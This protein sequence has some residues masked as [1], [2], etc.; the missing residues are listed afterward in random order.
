MRLLLIAVALAAT[1]DAQ[2]PTRDDYHRHLPP[3]PSIVAQTDASARLNLYGNRAAAGYVDRNPVDG[4][5]DARARRLLTIV[6]RFSPILRRNNFAIPR[7]F[8]DLLPSPR[9]LHVDVWRGGRRISSDSI[10]ID[11]A[12]AAASEGSHADRPNVGAAIDDDKLRAL[13]DALHPRRSRSRIVPASGRADTIVFVDL[14]GDDERSWRRAHERASAPAHVFAHVF[15]DD[16]PA[17]DGDARIHFEIQYW[18]YY[19]F[20]DS[21]NNHEGDWE[22]MTVCVTTRARATESLG[23][24]RTRGLPTEDDVARILNPASDALLDSLIIREVDY[25]FHHNVMTLDY[26]RALEPR[27]ASDARGRHENIW[28]DEDYVRHVIEKRVRWANGRLATH[29]IGYIGGNNLGPDELLRLVPR[30]HRSYNRNS[31]ATYP[32]PGV[33]LTIGPLG[34]TEKVR[35]QVVPRIPSD[36]TAETPWRELIGDDSFITFGESQI[37]LVPDW[38]RLDSLVLADA[39]VRRRWS[40]VVL[41]I[42]WGFPAVAS[43]GAGSLSHTNMGNLGPFGPTFNNAW[44]RRGETEEYHV[45]EPTVLHTPTSP[46]TPWANLVSG[47]GIL[48]VPLAIFGLTPGGNVA[49]SQLAP[50]LTGALHVVNKPPSKTITPGGLPSRFTNASFGASRQSRPYRFAPLLPHD[51]HAAVA[52]RLRGGTLRDAW[53]SAIDGPRIAFNLFFADRLSV[54]NTLSWSVSEVGYTIDPGDGSADARV[55]GE[56]AL[57]EFTG[58]VRWVAVRGFRDRLHLSAR[59]GAGWSQYTLRDVRIDEERIADGGHKGGRLPSVLPSKRWIPNAMYGGV[60]MEIF[61]AR[62]HYFLRRVG[63]GLR[64]ELTTVQH[65]L[66]DRAAGTRSGPVQHHTELAIA[67]VLGW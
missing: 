33:W 44:N 65:R 23:D 24:R 2:K 50:W 29:P 12:P 35:G 26:L 19:P 67:L 15:L 53:G 51:E 37:T 41:P 5:D 25:Y 1:A 45:F 20:N 63:Y 39:G 3:P 43:P 17:L 38:E 32:F 31:D 8:L 11:S 58:G 46:T 13:V 14:P 9:H 49:V 64:T 62:E 22:H 59:A 60:G 16:A 57:R 55:H 36:A 6:D 18:F 66:D 61:S 40:W 27:V 54:E 30:F 34:M 56:L 47:L 42:R 52:S 7:H 48:N 10:G 21:A 28:Q 4:I